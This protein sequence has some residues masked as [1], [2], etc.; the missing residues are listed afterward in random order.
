MNSSIIHDNICSL[1]RKKCHPKS[2]HSDIEYHMT[3]NVIFSVALQLRSLRTGKIALSCDIM[4]SL[5]P[6][7]FLGVNH[8][9]PFNF[10]FACED[11][12]ATHLT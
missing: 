1:G 9:I 10:W 11:L 7:I 5:C 3:L 8:G 6:V 4:F 2:Y 12:C